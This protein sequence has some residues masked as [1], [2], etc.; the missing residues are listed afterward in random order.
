[1]K[2]EV[3]APKGRFHRGAGQKRDRPLTRG[4]ALQHRQTQAAKS[5]KDGMARLSHEKALPKE[6]GREEKRLNARPRKAG[7][8]Q[9]RR[10]RAR[11]SSVSSTA[12]GGFRL[13]YDLHFGVKLDFELLPHQ[14]LRQADEL[15]RILRGG[16]AQILNKV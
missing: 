16:A 4:S 12:G 14:A 9:T 5:R 1:M 2:R 8:S 10:D 11:S 6:I 15:E 13:F 3:K 7:K